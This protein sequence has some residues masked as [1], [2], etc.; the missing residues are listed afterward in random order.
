MFR[1]MAELVN[2]F[3]FLSDN[4]PM[5]SITV[6][7]TKEIIPKSKYYQE[8]Y[9]VGKILAENNFTTITGGGAGIMEAANKGSLENGGKSIGVFMKMRNREMINKFTNKTIGFTFPFIR[10]MTLMAASEVLVFFPGSLGTMHNLFEVLTLLETNKIVGVKVVLY[11][12]D[13]WEPMREI[14]NNLYLNF[15]TISHNDRELINIIDS[16][17]ELSHYL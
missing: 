13:F 1:I 17:E 6:L 3:D 9:E 14:I 16:P 8:A 2:S 11:G 5:R 10:K 15:K 7:G 12:K 4:I